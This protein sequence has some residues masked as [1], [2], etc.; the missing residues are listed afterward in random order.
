MRLQHRKINK[1]E[2]TRDMMT[3]MIFAFNKL[4]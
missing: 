3:I 1:A 4:L 2:N